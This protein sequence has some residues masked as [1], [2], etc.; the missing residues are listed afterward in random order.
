MVERRAVMKAWAQRWRVARPA[1]KWG[2]VAGLVLILLLAV[3]QPLSDWL[4]PETRIQALRTSAER[5]LAQGRLTAAD[6][7]G[8]RELFEAALAL[9][10]DRPGAREGL[11][12]VGEAALLRAEAAIRAG[13]YPQARQHIALARSLR[14]PKA[15]LDTLERDIRQREIA[16]AGVGPRLDAARVARA[17]GH[18]HGG[19]DSALAHYAAVLEVEPGNTEA[20]EGRDDVIADV[21][22]D[23]RR[24]LGAGELEGPAKLIREARDFDPA[25]ADLPAALAAINQAL[26]ATRMQAERDLRNARLTRALAGYDRVLAV[27]PD[28]E[29]ARAGRRAV[30]EQLLQRSGRFAA[31]FRFAEAEATVAVAS[32]VLGHDPDVDEARARI[33]RARR[34]QAQ[35][36]VRPL[37]PQRQRRLQQLLADAAAAEARGDLLLPPGESA[38]DKVRAARAIAPDDRRVKAAMARLTPAARRCFDNAMR[39]NRLTTATACLDASRLLEPGVPWVATARNRLAQRWIAVG[40]ERVGAGEITTARRALDAAIALD[41]GVPGATE[42]AARLRQASA[43]GP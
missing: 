6:G 21:L 9:D 16:V 29:A 27:Q 30:G 32:T 11:V 38:F 28:N 31:D 43:A 22:A 34:A 19:P 20:L 15:R 36:N 18:L 1:V 23:A 42:L 41:P 37:T 39:D 35:L 12:R 26:E 7:S 33:G 8:A 3:R 17:A 4:W 10:P 40:N 24:Q 14:L 25:H 5:A 2:A 13:Q